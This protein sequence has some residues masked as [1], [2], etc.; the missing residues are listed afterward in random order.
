MAV[1]ES[2]P[3]HGKTT[4]HP[5]PPPRLRPSARR[6]VSLK[7]AIAGTRGVPARYGG[8][9]TFAAELSSRL[10]ARGHEVAVYCREESR[11]SGVGSRSDFIK[12][13]DSPIDDNVREPV[14][15]APT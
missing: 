1:E 6:M 9:E 8:F 3:D 14:V 4:R 13:P 10:A 11:E 7:I 15:S 5:E 2:A 12:V